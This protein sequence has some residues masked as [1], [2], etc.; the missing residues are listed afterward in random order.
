M[1][2]YLVPRRTVI[3]GAAALGGCSVLPRPAYVQRTTWPLSI[4]PPEQRPARRHG[5]VLVVRDFQAAPG[6]DQGG[7]QW[8]NPDGSVHVDFYN[9]WEVTPARAA[10][11][12]ARRWLA[13]SGLFA[14][15]IAP[16]SG[17]TADLTLEGE[18]TTFSADPRVLQGRAGLSLTLLDQRATPPRVRTQTTL[19]ATAHMTADTPSGVVA[20]QRAA[21]AS[22][23][24]QI[25][26][27]LARTA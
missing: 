18:L 10:A 15:V 22:L 3:A 13:A 7:V 27:L 26:G 23:M 14:A 2:R 5:K 20:A 8:L 4:A 11:D 9:L 17:L 1:N 25:V 16:D 12:D 19:A 24:G 21:L 6:L